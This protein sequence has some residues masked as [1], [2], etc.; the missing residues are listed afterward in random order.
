MPPSLKL[1]VPDQSYQQRM[2][3][4]AR[5]NAI[6]S[7]RRVMKERVRACEVSAV[8]LIAGSD[9]MLRTMRLADLLLCVPG[10]G[11]SKLRRMLTHNTVI[12]YSK[13]LGGLSVRQ[14][15]AILD[16]LAVYMEHSR[17][18]RNVMFADA[19]AA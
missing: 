3:H 8:D 7:Y 10:I 13:T 19:V 1:A 9:P 18:F 15:M 6:R 5:A 12:Q 16:S 11:H 17:R 14:R 2:D 4:L